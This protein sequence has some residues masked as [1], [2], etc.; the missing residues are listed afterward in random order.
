MNKDFPYLEFMKILIECRNK[1]VDDTLE[2]NSPDLYDALYSDVNSKVF[3]VKMELYELK[4]MEMHWK[5]AIHSTEKKELTNKEKK[6]IVSMFAEWYKQFISHWSYLDLDIVIFEERINILETLVLINN[7]WEQNL[8]KIEV[9]FEQS[10][11]QLN[12]RIKELKGE[13]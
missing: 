2:N 5:M 9:S 8:K 12:E 1:I 11:R 10:R 13:I 7:K 4:W 6:E 3:D